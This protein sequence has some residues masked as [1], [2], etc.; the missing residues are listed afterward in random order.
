MTGLHEN[1]LTW[2][3]F[4]DLELET[5]SKCEVSERPP[6]YHQLNHIHEYNTCHWLITELIADLMSFVSENFAKPDE[7]MKGIINVRYE[8]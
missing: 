8:I 7:E 6:G 4:T 5:A 3:K 2:N 1:K